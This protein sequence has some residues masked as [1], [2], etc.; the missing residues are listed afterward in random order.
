MNYVDDPI[1][2][3]SNSDKPKVQETHHH[4][5]FIWLHLLSIPGNSIVVENLAQQMDTTRNEDW[6][7]LE[8]S[9]AKYKEDN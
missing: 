7:K 2:Q 6:L 5:N 8:A 3:H 9:N 4:S 1:E